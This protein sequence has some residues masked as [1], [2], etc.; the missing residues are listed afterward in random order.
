[1][2]SC[3]V[4]LAVD[5]PS[6]MTECLAHLIKVSDASVQ[7]IT[8]TLIALLPD[9][10]FRKIVLKPNWV[11]HE[12][13][14]AFPISALVTSTTVIEATLGACLEKYPAAEEITVGDVPLQGCD[15]ELLLDQAG[16]RALA[17]KYKNYKRPVVRFLDLR[18]E[19]AQVIRGYVRQ[20]PNPGGGDPKGYREIV[21]DDESFLDPISRET[22]S[23]RVSDYRP[24]RT[25]SSHRRGF[26]R[27][28]I[29][30]SVLDCDLLINLPKVKTHQKTGITGAL[31]N[32]VGINGEK[33][34]LVHYRRNFN[35]K[36]GDEFPPDVPPVVVWQT[37]IRDAMQGHSRALF[38]LLGACW[39]LM[40]KSSGIETQGTPENLR[41]GKRFF[42]SPGAWYGNDTI[43][44]MVYDLNIIVR[45]AARDGNRLCDR[46][47]REYF[48][49]ADGIV[50]GEGNGPLQPLPVD[51]GVILAASDPF[52]LDMLMARTMGLAYQRMPML[53][54]ARQFGR[55]AWGD[56]DP[57]E[58]SIVCDGQI[59]RGIDA[60]PIL[61]SFI[62]PPGWQG[63]I[64]L[65]MC[66]A[67]V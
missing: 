2:A 29:A 20:S 28:L 8:R 39:Q 62:P 51:F 45:F 56:F 33:G 9:G 65:N 67:I 46:P 25:T 6:L 13:Q 40:R 16:I 7:S 23:F 44:R 5:E 10:D 35:G 21:L 41:A 37:R 66:E 31:K 63:Q 14:P 64:E 49:I 32:L 18:R 38:T 1:M 22:S 43:W 19:R 52:L 26:H 34:Y 61:R 30:R 24:D 60:V 57:E 4:S 17:E 27:Y 11:K 15:W 48:A 58:A 42:V 59:L 12:E 55:G 54:N 47:Q 36:E 3:L 50:A 53:A